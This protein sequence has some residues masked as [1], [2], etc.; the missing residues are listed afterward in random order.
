MLIGTAICLVSIAVLLA[1]PVTLSYQLSRRQA[2]EA[3]V[4]LRWMFG[5]VRLELPLT[6]R[7]PAASK[8]GSGTR[9]KRQDEATG[10]G[11]N[12]IAV[13][14]HHAFRKRLVRFLRDVWGAVHMQGLRLR[15]RIG[16]GD[17]A[18]TGQ[19]WAVMGPLSGILATIQSASIEIEPE[20]VDPVFELDSSGTIHLVPLR[21]IY[22]GLGLAASPSFW[23]GIRKMR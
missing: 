8:R 6:P 21:M 20:F 23:Q 9:R 3:T 10:R 18:D 5:L 7:R 16:L 11:K 15:V 19:L 22:L 2:L 13:I 17:P 12:A 4:K 14:R 1:V